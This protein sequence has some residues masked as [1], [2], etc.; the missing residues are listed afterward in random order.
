MER[1][2][3]RLGIGVVPEPMLL[4]VEALRDFWKEDWLRDNLMGRGFEFWKGRLIKRW[5]TLF[6]LF[7]KVGEGLVP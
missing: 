6:Q 4:L 1:W 3:K 5:G 7:P 2:A